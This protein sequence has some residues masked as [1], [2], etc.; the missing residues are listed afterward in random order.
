MSTK[1]KNRECAECNDVLFTAS[2]SSICA[3]CAIR[4]KKEKASLDQKSQLNLWGY[5]VISGPFANKFGKQKYNLLGPCCG[6]EFSATYAD[7]S[8]GVRGNQKKGISR[9]PCGACGPRNRMQVALNGYIEKYARDYDLSQYTDYCKLVRGLS[10]VVY[11]QNKPVLNP[12]NLKRGRNHGYHLDHKM[13]IIEC[14]KQN[15]APE[16]AAALENLQ[17]LPWN[18]NLSK[19]SNLFVQV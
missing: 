6:E 13:P 16:K 3:K 11:K 14:F 10:E 17:L 19:G 18:E 15:F 9:M 4:K 1:F 8:S 5:S 12:D 7:I 2:K